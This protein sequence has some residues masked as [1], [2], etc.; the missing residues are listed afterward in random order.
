MVVKTNFVKTRR[1]SLCMILIFG[2]FTQ[3]RAQD[4]MTDEEEEQYK[5]AINSRINNLQL[6]I[7]QIANKE[8]E[9]ALRKGSITAAVK[10][11]VND[12]M[13]VQVGSVTTGDINSYKVGTYF[14]RL[15]ALPAKNVKITFFA[16]ISFSCQTLKSYFR[17]NCKLNF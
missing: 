9:D 14:Y 5:V 7:D 2:S 12:T 13:K 17:Q 8:K 3:I 16:I 15:Y 4:V 10:L 6:Y 1:L 11:F